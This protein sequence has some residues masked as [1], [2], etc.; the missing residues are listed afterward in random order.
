MFRN[1]FPTALLWAIGSVAV[2]LSAADTPPPGAD[3]LDQAF[4]SL[5]TY[6]WG[7][8]R[9]SLQTLDVAVAASHGDA[10]ARRN[11]ETRLV[12]VLESDASRAAKDVV[13]R[14]LSLIGSANA[15]PALAKLLP[16]KDLSHMARYALERIPDAAA[17]AALRSA[18]ANTEGLQKI[19]VIDSVGI[20]RDAD[21]VTALTALVGDSNP[22]IAAAAVAALGA[23][24][25]SEA[26]QA[27]ATAQASVPSQLQAAV[28][29]ARLSCAE[30]LLAAGKK[31]EALA[32]YKAL[33]SEDQPQHIRVAA[34][35]GM[36]AA[37]GQK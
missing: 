26:A 31:A 9:T 23:I 13:C 22:Q 20:R 12:G 4:A 6:Q 7:Q 28:A 10:A 21:S 36:L 11:L 33:N 37:A 2:P 35:R 17:T 15:V 24:G 25:T 19:G 8:D 5:Q 1:V 18:L 34:V 29:D 32:I 30:R 27:L 16:D 14:Q 3:V